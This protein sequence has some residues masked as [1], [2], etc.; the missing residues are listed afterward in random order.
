MGTVLSRLRLWQILKGMGISM[1]EGVVQVTVRV[2]GGM[3]A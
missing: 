3:K 1:A 2:I